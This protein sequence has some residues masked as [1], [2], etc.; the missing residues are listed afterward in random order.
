MKVYISADIEGITGVT[1][2]D[3]TNIQKDES[4][5]S[6]EQMTA[7]VSAACE[8]ALQAGATEIWVKDAHWTGR[9]INHAKLP[10]EAR[11]VRGWGPHPLMMVQELDGSFQGAA[12]IGYHSRAGA[13]TSPLAH[14]ITG[15]YA[16][17]KINDLY[18]SE[19]LIHSYAAAFLKV[20]SLFVSGDKGICDEAVQLIP[21]IETVAVKEGIGDFDSEHPSQAC[22]L[23]NPLRDGK[24]LSRRP[25]WLPP[26]TPGLILKWKS[27]TRNISMPI[28]LA[29]SRALNRLAPLQSSSKARIISKC[30][31]FFSSRTRFQLTWD[32]YKG[33][34]DVRRCRA[35]QEIAQEI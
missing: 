6:R 24:S 31:A 27:P 26:G 34:R 23:P 22:D 9:N 5:T 14:T 10:Q 28:S 30:F 11:L 3:E 32:G 25:G 35:D 19:F 29:F 7:E 33:A 1:H 17:I 21:G 12:F 13:N 15:K 20:P 18:A 2:W 8:G 16:S 4:E